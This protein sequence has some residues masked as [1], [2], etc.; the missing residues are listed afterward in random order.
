MYNIN[1]SL[2]NTVYDG[3]VFQIYGIFGRKSVRCTGR[4]DNGTSPLMSQSDSP[5]YFEV[6]FQME[7][8]LKTMPTPNITSGVM[9]FH[10]FEWGTRT[11][12]SFVSLAVL[13]NRYL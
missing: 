5:C 7:M 10:S 8:G 1:F 3:L 12:L 2:G 9:H 4:W 13:Y 11:T 6:P